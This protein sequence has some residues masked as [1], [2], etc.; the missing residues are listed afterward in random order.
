MDFRTRKDYYKPL[1]ID[2]P[3]CTKYEYAVFIL[4]HCIAFHFVLFQI[5]HISY[6]IP[7]IKVCHIF[8]IINT[9]NQLEGS[10]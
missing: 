8:V 10:S 4:L 5:N 6:F 1:T 9:Y 2:I 7:I 3:A